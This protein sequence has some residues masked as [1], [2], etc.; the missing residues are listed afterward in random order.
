MRA[1]IYVASSLQIIA[2]LFRSKNLARAVVSAQIFLGLG[3]LVNVV[4]QTARKKLYLLD[5]VVVT[6][7]FFLTSGGIQAHLTE[8]GVRGTR[9]TLIKCFG[10]FF[11]LCFGAWW[12][13]LMAN[14][15]QFGPHP[16]CNDKTIVVIFW[17]SIRVTVPWLRILCFCLEGVICV[18]IALDII[19]YFWSENYTQ[20]ESKNWNNTPSLCR[21]ILEMGY[22]IPFAFVV[23]WI[24]LTIRRN[25]IGPGVNEWTFGQTMAAML[26][27]VSFVSFLLNV[28]DP[29]ALRLFWLL[30]DCRQ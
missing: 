15:E 19:L 29:G 28:V 7:Y 8:N 14:A 5:A 17:V 1:I 12:I 22:L 10:T 21:R 30:I 23:S 4:I 20:G 24:E 27:F 11:H 18:F 26:Y 2:V 3:L 13:Y 9:I 25:N 6:Y 16:E